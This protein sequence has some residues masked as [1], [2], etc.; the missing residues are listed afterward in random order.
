MH[1]KIHTITHTFLKR[2]TAE[3][4][5]EYVQL[6]HYSVWHCVHLAV[7]PLA[8]VHCVFFTITSVT[9]QPDLAYTSVPY[10]FTVVQKLFSV[11][12]VSISCARM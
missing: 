6:I 7:F 12:E 8:G 1:C 10:T 4:K 2:T 9:L 3:L 11:C 5:R